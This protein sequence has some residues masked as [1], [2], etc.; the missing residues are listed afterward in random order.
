MITLFSYL[1]AVFGFKTKCTEPPNTSTPNNDQSVYSYTVYLCPCYVAANDMSRLRESGRRKLENV[2]SG[3]SSRN[4]LP[5]EAKIVRWRWRWFA[6]RCAVSRS[7]S[8][9]SISYDVLTRCL[10]YIV[11]RPL[12]IEDKH[13]NN[14]NNNSNKRNTCQDLI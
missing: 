2:P 8:S 7:T 5:I 10:R 3:T 13:S 9:V 11:C 4:S 12:L 6:C 14:N 1:S